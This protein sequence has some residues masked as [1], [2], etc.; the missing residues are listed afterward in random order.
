MVMLR[1]YRGPS[2]YH[3]RP[4][5]DEAEVFSRVLTA[6]KTLQAMPDQERRFLASGTKAAWP[7]TLVEFS[8][9][10]AQAEM[11]PDTDAIRGR[12]NLR[13]S[14]ISDALIAGDWFAKLALIHENY[15]QFQVRLHDYRS[16]KRVSPQ[17][18]DQKFLSWYA[19]GWSLKNIGQRFGI[20]EHQAERRLYEIARHLWRIANRTARLVEPES[21]ERGRELAEARDALRGARA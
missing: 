14:E 16:H 11:P 13:S 4:W 7:P 20:N 17:V 8:D 19:H 15:P 9:L 12:V 6:I 21:T 10:V 18:D 5:I 2:A 1:T 3:Y